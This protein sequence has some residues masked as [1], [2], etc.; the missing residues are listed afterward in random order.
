MGGEGGAAAGS[1][2]RDCAGR[3]GAPSY[4]LHTTWGTEFG[5][6]RQRA[7]AKSAPS[8]ASVIICCRNR[9]TVL[10]SIIGDGPITEQPPGVGGGISREADVRYFYSLVTRGAIL[11][12]LG[13]QETRKNSAPLHKRKQ[14]KNKTHRRRVPPPLQFRGVLRLGSR[15][16]HKKL[17][18][19]RAYPSGGALGWDEAGGHSKV[20]SHLDPSCSKKDTRFA[21]KPAF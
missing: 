17:Q 4:D 7:L 19:A 21:F 5:A 18:S 2:R 6:A 3:P 11:Y 9:V 14:P 16:Y 13:K 15:D 12:S 1:R 8:L 10:S 20:W